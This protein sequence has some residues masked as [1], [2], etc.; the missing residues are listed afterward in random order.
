MRIPRA[1]LLSLVLL[2]A[3]SPSA[4]FGQ[5]AEED[6]IQ[7]ASRV[8]KEVMAIPLKGIPATLLKDAQG[9]AIVPGLIKGGFIVGVEHGKGV[10]IVR[11][12]NGAWQSPSFITITGGGIGWQAGLQ[13]T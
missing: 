9:V 6:T 2:L 12:K 1:W 5:A 4:V 11:D 8:L 3:A 7:G 10:V 13:A